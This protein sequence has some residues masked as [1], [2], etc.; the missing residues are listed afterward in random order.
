MGR[1]IVTLIVLA[2]AP[3][4]INCSSIGATCGRTARGNRGGPVR[5]GLMMF[6]KRL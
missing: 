6:V 4:A 5:L 3:I 2:V 1:T